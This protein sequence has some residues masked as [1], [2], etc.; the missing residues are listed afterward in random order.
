MTKKSV[1]KRARTPRGIRNNNPGNIRAS[2][3]VWKGEV[4]GDGVFES[5]ESPEMGI[6]AMGKLIAT[7]RKKYGLT[8]IRGIITRWAPPT[9]ND[10]ANYIDRVSNWSGVG[11]DVVVSDDQMPRVIAAM[12]RMENGQCPYSEE[13]IKSALAA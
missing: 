12:V 11:A 10:T 7:Y 5:F 9:E 8:T 6:R 13:F 1:K 3:I 2:S 4:R